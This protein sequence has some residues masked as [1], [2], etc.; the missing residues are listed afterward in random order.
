MI[1]FLSKDSV[2]YTLKEKLGHDVSHLSSRELEDLANSISATQKAA[3][4]VEKWDT[5]V[6]YSIL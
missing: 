1:E 5:P 2:L 3:M 4:E 6:R